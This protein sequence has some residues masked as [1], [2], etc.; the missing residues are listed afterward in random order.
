MLYIPCGGTARNLTTFFF[1][2][3]SQILEPIAGIQ[4]AGHPEDPSK[5][6]YFDMHIN[7]LH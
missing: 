1:Y 7:T 6:T 2:W 4:S 3:F 5:G